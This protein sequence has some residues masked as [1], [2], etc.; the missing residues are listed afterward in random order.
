MKKSK[1]ILPLVA[2]FCVLLGTANASVKV[3]TTG[4][5]KS[6]NL[7]S[8]KC[9]ASQ[10]AQKMTR[11]LF[12][13]PVTL[14]EMGATA[15]VYRTYDWSISFVQNGVTV[16]SF[17]T[18]DSSTNWSTYGPNDEV[19]TGGTTTVPAGTYTVIISNISGVGGT[20]DIGVSYTDASGQGNGAWDQ[21]VL[22]DRQDAV[23]NDISVDGISS[24]DI[25][26]DKTQF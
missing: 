25:V 5:P 8:S 23:F 15:N 7:Y 9:I 11:R 14:H 18:N 16:A 17:Y 10:S 3:K 26:V 12:D 24:I 21:D 19:W 22:T 20:Y 6:G 13:S 2:L 1:L 4:Q